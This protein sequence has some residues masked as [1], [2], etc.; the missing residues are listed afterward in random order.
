MYIILYIFIC[1]FISAVPS[2]AEGNSLPELTIQKGHS[3]AVNGILFTKDGRKMMS[4]SKDGIIQIRETESWKLINSIEGHTKSVEGILLTKN[5]KK[6]ISYSGDGSIK[7]WN[8]DNGRLIMKLKGKAKDISGLLLVRNEK[9]LISRSVDYTVEIWDLTEGKLLKSLNDHSNAVW[10]L[11]VT[12][13]ESKLI[14]YSYKTVYVR[15]L[16]TGSL[17]F[18]LNGHNNFI[19]EI[20]LTKDEKKLISHSF[21]RT[22]K[23]WNMETGSLLKT[24]NAV[25]EVRITNDRNRFLLFSANGWMKIMESDTG[26]LIKTIKDQFSFMKTELTGDDKR[27]ISVSYQNELDVRNLETGK[28]LWKVK[29]DNFLI[30]E[31]KKETVIISVDEKIQVR[32]SKTGKII[33]DMEGQ[34]ER[35]STHHI[36]KSKNR[37]ASYSDTEIRIWDFKTGKSIKILKNSGS[38]YSARMEQDR[39][40]IKNMNEKMSVI[41]MKTGQNIGYENKINDKNSIT[42]ELNNGKIIRS[43]EGHSGETKGITFSRN[44][45]RIF[46]FSDDNII[47]V[48][49]NE[50][51]KKIMSLVGHTDAIQELSLSRDESK[52]FSYSWDNTVRIWDVNSGTCLRIL[53]HL[54]SSPVMIMEEQ[55][56]SLTFIISVSRDKSVRYWDIETGKLLLTQIVSTE[57][58]EGSIFYTPDGRFDYTD[59]Y[60]SKYISFRYENRF[61]DKEKFHNQFYT[62][63]L[64][65][66]VMSETLNRRK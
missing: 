19:R 53:E 21:D 64:K 61:M 24:I 42:V 20:F 37:L 46:S 45:K 25:D 8:T 50:T 12:Y 55:I 47:T 56:S 31:D 59:K 18:Q 1:S 13:D 30:S 17:I 62:Q 2:F 6:L 49:D 14:S 57:K 63:N 54:T 11:T 65:E 66:K 5:E 16:Q 32:E 43:F 39:L 27:L 38:I 22:V 52:I 3:A 9:I 40:Y 35:T 41:D 10:G 28:I 33:R 29:G 60:L 26:R 23:I 36:L 7:I 51:G 34:L 48:W 44:K 58:G 4:W 15:D